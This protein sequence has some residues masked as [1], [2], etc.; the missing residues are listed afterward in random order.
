MSEMEETLRDV[1]KACLF[2]CPCCRTR[3]RVRPTNADLAER[4]RRL[5]GIYG[6]G[7]PTHQLLYDAAKALEDK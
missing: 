6:T 4:L 2:A 5:A 1:R 7:E 3:E